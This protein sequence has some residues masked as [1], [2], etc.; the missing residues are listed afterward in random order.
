[1]RTRAPPLDGGNEDVA[2][3]VSAIE[4]H[5][6]PPDFEFVGAKVGEDVAIDV[7]GGRLG[8]AGEVVHLA[9]GR[10]VAEDV[11]GFV[12]DAP[13]G[14]PVDGFV[15]PGATGLDEE[16][17][18]LGHTGLRLERGGVVSV[19]FGEVSREE[20]D[21]VTETFSDVRR[22]KDHLSMVCRPDEEEGEEV[23]QMTRA[24]DQA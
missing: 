20:H 6:L 23:G 7:D 16:A 22:L 10:G 4:L 5:A 24:R 13:V 8:L 9:P 3:P 14:E 12:G 2:S 19:F 15:A 11:E 18:G 17:D 1:M 21:Q